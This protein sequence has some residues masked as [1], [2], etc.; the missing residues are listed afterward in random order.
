MKGI[1]RGRKWLERGRREGRIRKGEWRI[2]RGRTGGGERER[3][4]GKGEGR[5][6]AELIPHH[7]ILDPPLQTDGRADTGRQ[8]RPRLRMGSRGKK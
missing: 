3:R 4:E 5:R 1:E 2:M 8:Q 7:E 6:E